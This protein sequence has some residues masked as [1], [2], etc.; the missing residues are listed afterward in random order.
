MDDRKEKLKALLQ[1]NQPKIIEGP[2]LSERF[3]TAKN[4]MMEPS[5]LTDEQLLEDPN[6]TATL[7]GEGLVK[8]FRAGTSLL[9]QDSVDLGNGVQFDPT[10]AMGSISKIGALTK[11][12]D[13]N[14]LK[15]L[16]KLRELLES[17]N[18]KVRPDAGH[19]ML[20]VKPEAAQA[21]GKVK[22]KP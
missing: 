2:S 20:A 10:G 3:D 17:Q 11:I 16:E 9:P 7:G 13:A 21:F 4:V 1:Q 18:F 6:P 22:V 12:K 19:G 5:Q 15:Q 8:L 14:K